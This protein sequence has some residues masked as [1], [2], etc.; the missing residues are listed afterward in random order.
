VSV[1]TIR[2]WHIGQGW[3][4]IGYHW[5]VML[6]GTALPERPEAQIGSHVAGHRNAGCRLRR[7]SRG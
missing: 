7:R 3:K 5:V 4:D 1:D 2:S 6:D